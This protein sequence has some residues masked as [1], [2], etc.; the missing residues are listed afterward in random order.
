MTRGK[1]L[2]L[3]KP[4]TPAWQQIGRGLGGEIFD[5]FENLPDAM[6]AA[7]APLSQ[8]ARVAAL[9][10]AERIRQIGA[11]GDP[12]A[13]WKLSGAELHFGRAKDA[14]AALDLMIECLKSA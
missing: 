3:A 7:C 12:V 9:P 4:E 8:E 13:L 6:R 5:M 11:P 14:R 10:A 2:T 1:A